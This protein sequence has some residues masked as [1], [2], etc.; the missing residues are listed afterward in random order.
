MNELNELNKW[1]NKLIKKLNE[2]VKNLLNYET[3]TFT[4]N[5]PNIH[6]RRTQWAHNS[7]KNNINDSMENREIITK[8]DQGK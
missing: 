8:T 2:S 5:G 3:F 4:F 6:S 1:I 7:R